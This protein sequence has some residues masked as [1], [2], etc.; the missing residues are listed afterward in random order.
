MQSLEE[1]AHRWNVPEVALRELAG[2]PAFEPVEPSRP[3]TSEGGVQA[4]VRLEAAR[5]GVWAWRN[6]V[7]GGTLDNGSFVRWGLANDSAAL[8]ARLKSSDLV[9]F[10]RRLI[11]PADIGSYLA[12]FWARECKPPGWKFTGTPREKAQLRFITLIQ[13]NGGDAAFANAEGSVK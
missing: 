3:V 7:G 12:Q 2:V 6:N 1:W 11:L 5:A 9:G 10:R 4:L 13:S 8:N